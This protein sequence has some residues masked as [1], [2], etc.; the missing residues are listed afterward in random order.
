MTR[1]SS[2]YPVLNGGVSQRTERALQLNQLREQLNMIYD[3]TLGLTRRPGMQYAESYAWAGT[4]NVPATQ[5][6]A[7]SFRDFPL[8]VGDK[9][10]AVFCRTASRVTDT[11]LD[12]A[13][14]REFVVVDKSTASMLPVW[15]RDPGDTTLDALLDGGV[16]AAASVGDL[17][18]LAG[19]TVLPQYERSYPWAEPSNQ[20]QHI[21]WVRGGAYSRAFTLKLVRGNQ[22]CSIEYTTLDATYPK[23]LD[24]SDLFPSDPEYSKKVNDR[25]NAYNSEATAWIAQALADVTPENIATKLADGLRISGFLSPGGTVEVVNSSVVINDL[26]V[27]EVEADDGGDNNLM[28]AVGNVVGAPELLTV[29]GYPGKIVKVRPGNSQRGEVF[30]L[31]ARAKDGSSGAYTPVTWEE[32]AG[33]VSTP[34][35]LFCYLTVAGGQVYVSSDMAWLNENAGTN[36]PLP[37]ENIA[38]DLLS[39]AP[40]EFEGHVITAMTTFQDRLVVCRRDGYVASSVPGDYLNFFRASAVNVTDTDP[41]SFFIIGGDGDTVRWAVQYDRS[42]ILVGNKRQ[43]L[44]SSRQQFVPGQGAAAPFTAIAGMATIE[45]RVV[46]DSIF[47]AR[48][49]NGYASLHAVRPGRI[50]ES[51]YEVE[52]S[53]EINTLITSPGLELS[54]LTTPDLVVLR[55][56]DSKLYVANYEH[57]DSGQRYAVHVWDSPGAGTLVGLSEYAGKLILLWADDAELRTEII[58][59]QQ[60]SRGVQSAV[61]YADNGRTYVS[62]AVLVS[63]RFSTEGGGIRGQSLGEQNFQKQRLTISDMTVYFADTSGAVLTVTEGAKTRVINLQPKDTL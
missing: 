62:R 39:N 55:A 46:G 36:F 41:V 49:N 50:A 54:T 4:G 30:Y 42:L 2:M 31:R 29:L 23:V 60:A 53:A 1:V 17:L 6:D 3:P 44:L 28:R 7:V 40:P 57:T 26:T 48:Y 15:N 5:A 27:E 24:T 16:S 38:G 61:P 11:F 20:R 63:P 56:A 12:D 58:E 51:P 14:F 22:K 25:T 21:V 45:P 8:T 43:Y 9:D 18:V 47:F 10:Y 34:T 13:N 37:Q 19:N 52:V 35:T 33:E 59:F 32:A